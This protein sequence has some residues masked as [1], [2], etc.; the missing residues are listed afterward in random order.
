MEE[1]VKITKEKKEKVKITKEK[2]IK[3]IAKLSG[4]NI[5]DVKE[6]YNTLENIIFENLSSVSKDRDICIKLFEGISLDGTF[7]SEK[8]KKSNLKKK[9][10]HVDSKIKPKFNITR[11]YVDKLNKQN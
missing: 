7:T 10:I 2:I 3:D 11:Y 4:K 5:Y 1:K 6:I 9:L 8:I